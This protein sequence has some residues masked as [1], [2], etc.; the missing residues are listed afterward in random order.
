MRRLAYDAVW[1]QD[2]VYGSRVNRLK[3]ATGAIK[4][5]QREVETFKKLYAGRIRYPDS[6]VEDSSRLC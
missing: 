3:V 5:Q 1:W 2:R 4:P 6:L